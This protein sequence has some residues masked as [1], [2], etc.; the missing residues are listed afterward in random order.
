MFAVAGPLD[1]PF[2][3]PPPS[4]DVD[5]DAP[6]SFLSRIW[7]E[8]DAIPV[9]IQCRDTQFSLSGEAVRAVELALETLAPTTTNIVQAA[10]SPSRREV[11]GT[12]QNPSDGVVKLIACCV[13]SGR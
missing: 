8:L 3:M 6:P 7:L 1:A 12:L 4:L 10:T 11:L 2:D 5:R 13:F 9:L